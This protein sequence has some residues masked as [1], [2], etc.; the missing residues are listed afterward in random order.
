MA[1]LL[2]RATDWLEEQRKAHLARLVTYQRGADSVAV[3]ATMGRKTFDVAAEYGALVQVDATDFIVAA[4]DLV[5]GG[6]VVVPQPG[7]RV[8]VP[9]GDGVDVYEVMGPGPDQ[10]C[11]EPADPYRKAWRIHT[12]L[13]RP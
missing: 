5:L 9:Q 1:D 6:G 10:A 7:D 11:C 2:E 3:W 8:R 12:K 4:A 13:V